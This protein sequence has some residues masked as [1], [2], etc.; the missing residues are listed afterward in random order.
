V[1]ARFLSISL[2]SLL[3]FESIDTNA[4]IY[5][6]IGI[7]VGV[8][9]ADEECDDDAPYYDT[10]CEGNARGRKLFGG[11]RVHKYAAVEVSYMDMGEL[12]KTIDM[13][14][15]TAEPTGTNI[16]I[17]GIYPVGD[18]QSD[19]FNLE[20]FGKLGLLRWDTMVINHASGV[21]LDDAGTDP[22]YGIGVSVGGENI[23]FTLEF[24][25]L[26]EINGQYSPG[27]STLT[28]ASIG[29]MYRF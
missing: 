17:V 15:I 1:L 9:A 29:A 13:A 12:A 26:N 6:Y 23:F 2:F 21:S 27:G 7:S 3:L 25:V 8:S 24:E 22:S 28:Y 16:S 11:I 14:R 5:P 10:Q 19:S 18:Y 4:E 20:L